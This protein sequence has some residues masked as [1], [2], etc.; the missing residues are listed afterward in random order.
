MKTILVVENY[1]NQGL[2]YEEEFRREGYNVMLARNGR[3]AITK[4]KKQITD[5]IIM[6]IT[7]PVIEHRL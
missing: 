2:L 7:M 3:E 4:I 6:E 5:I 1:K